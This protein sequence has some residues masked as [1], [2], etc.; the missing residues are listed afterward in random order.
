MA[1]DAGG[2]AITMPST[3]FHIGAL[4]RPPCAPLSVN[5]AARLD[6]GL[7]V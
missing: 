7:A 3:F 6:W 1:A 5:H 4:W 2:K